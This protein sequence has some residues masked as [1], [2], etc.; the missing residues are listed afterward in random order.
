MKEAP[1]Q[2]IYGPV[3][4][5]RLGQSLGVD[6]VPFKTCTYD[7]IYCQ[8]GHTTNKTIKRMTY[9]EED[10]II[11][12]L[13]RKLAT[14]CTPDYIS[15]AG[16]GEPTLHAGIGRLIV[17]I[18][19][20]TRLPVAV[21]TNGSLLWKSEV[22]D[23]LLE[24]DLVLPSLDAGSERLFMFVNRPHP[25]IT[26]AK[27]L[28]G[29]AEFT[30][31]FTKSVWLEIFLL[32]GITGVASEVEKIAELVRCIQPE[33]VQLNTV[34]RP[35]CEEIA[36]AVPLQDM[37]MFS[38]MFPVKAE[39]IGDTGHIEGL[40]AKPA[41]VTDTD[42]L[43]LLSRRP[44]TISD[45]SSGLGIHVAEAAKRLQSL[46]KRGEVGTVRQKGRLF[47]KIGKSK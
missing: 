4:S 3:P 1:F 45:I 6:L 44:C 39:V 42:I 18:K 19:G 12:E 36:H 20:L 29:L 35:P 5:R 33:R 7:C 27:M 24:A 43:G 13:E 40:Y 22:Q 17:R 26:F 14:G 28:D 32:A 15:L 41:G 46:F 37:K 25:E 30:R 21:L 38:E 11:A 2:Y 34:S 16:S 23:A 9:V 47:Y 31:C 10:A 8:L